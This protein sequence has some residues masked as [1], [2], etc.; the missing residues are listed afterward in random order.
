MC[1]DGVYPTVVICRVYLLQADW[2]NDRWL[3]VS[4][5]IVLRLRLAIVSFCPEIAG[6]NYWRKY[7]LENDT[8]CTVNSVRRLHDRHDF[9]VSAHD[10]CL[11]LQYISVLKVDSA[12]GTWGGVEESQRPE[13]KLGHKPWTPA[14]GVER[15]EDPLTSLITCV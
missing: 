15:G 9:P 8:C 3:V 12:G 1:R 13:T 11:L 14:I 5:M 4:L 7:L 6:L 10:L 2:R